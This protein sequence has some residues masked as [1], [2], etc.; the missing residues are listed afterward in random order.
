[1]GDF[2]IPF[3]LALGRQNNFFARTDNLFGQSDATP[4]VTAGNLF[5][6]NNTSNTTITNFDLVSNHTTGN[7]AGQFEG[8]VITVMFLDD[9]TRLANATPLYLS[10]SDGLQGANNIISLVYH[11]SGWYETYRSIN[12]SNFVTATSASLG[13]TGTVSARGRDTVILSSAAGSDPVLRLLTNGEQ[14][15]RV[16]VVC[17]GSNCTIV[18]NSG[19]NNQFVTSSS[20]GAATVILANSAALSFTRIGGQW[21]ELRDIG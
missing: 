2:R 8:K 18:V 19:G 16:N 3:G 12:V 15:Q 13:A 4:D 9:S 14:G 17:S 7:N 5:F 10:G 6:S 1:M 20:S 11:N 21:L